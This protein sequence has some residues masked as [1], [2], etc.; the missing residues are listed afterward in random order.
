MVKETKLYDSLGVSPDASQDDL[1]RAYKKLALKYHPDKN[2]DAG[3]QFK[4]ISH[5]YEV[6][7]DERKRQQYDQ[8]GESG[9]SGDGGMGV[10]A[11]DLFSQLFGGGFFGGGGPRQ[12]SGPRKG[13]DMVHPI[14][15]TLEELH[16]G[17]VKKLA[18]TRNIVCAKCQGRGGKEGAV[19]EC[20]TCH[21]RGVRVTMRQIGPMIQQMQSVCPDCRGEG[22]VIREKDRCKACH[23]KKVVN[24]RKVLEVHVDK[25][26][27]GGQ[28]IR[29]QGEA[30]QAPDI[31]PGDV[32][33][34]IE[35]IE[36]STFKRKGDHLFYEAKIDL[37]T[38]L[39]GGQ[40][41]I[42]HLDDRQLVVTICPG[43]VITPGDVK[44]I[45]GEGM[46]S[47]RHHQNGNLFVKFEIDFP[48]HGWGT[49]EQ[50]EM[51]EK[52][53]PPKKALPPPK[54]R[55][56]EEVVLSTLDATQQQ[57]ANSQA[58]GHDDSDED[59]HGHPGVSCQQQ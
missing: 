52:A 42:P 26:M 13:K 29:F 56:I 19:K 31:V 32:V 34:V 16:K 57:Q 6:L 5:A 10:S 46:P 55:E 53:L 27:R 30:D 48:P 11:E 45:T 18:L 12:P 41:A 44:V 43:E 58:N 3:D 33:I 36:H 38:A 1:K 15:A 21:G 49:P 23:G 20:G 50:V 7:S 4:E 9:L 8:F 22:E 17:K 51:L 35:E 37:L 28:Q 25:G 40:F 59:D 54:G 14:K 2:P 39:A 47:Y 24:D